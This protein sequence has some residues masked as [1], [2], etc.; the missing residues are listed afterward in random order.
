[1]NAINNDKLVFLASTNDWESW[2]LQFQAQAV[3][4]DLW[5]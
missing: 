4:G 2:N 1:M 5:S 3:A